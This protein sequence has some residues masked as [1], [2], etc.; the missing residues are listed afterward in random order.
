M[1]KFKGYL[2]G[3]SQKFFCNKIVKSLKKFVGFTL[4]PSAIII[5]LI[6]YF[7]RTV[8][9]DPRAIISTIILVAIGLMLPKILTKKEKEK[10][11]PQ[12]VCIKNN[13][14]ISHSNELIESRYIEDVKEVK[15]YG[16]FYYL[17]FP[18]GKYSY[19]FVCQKDLLSQGTLEDFEALFEGK[20]VRKP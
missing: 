20:I 2:T 7:D 13:I 4:I 15:D 9:T 14:I 8:V 19:R 3:N 6:F 10:I 11:T 18:F 16:E 5:Y 12:R 17:T 1:I